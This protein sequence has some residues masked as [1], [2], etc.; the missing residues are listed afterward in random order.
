M[1]S[2]IILLA[3]LFAIASSQRVE[4]QA[5]KYVLMEHFTNAGCAPCAAQNPIFDTAILKRNY[6]RVHHLTYHTSWPGTDPM[7]TYNPA[8][9]QSRVTYYDVTGVPDIELS[10]NQ[11]SGIPLGVSQKMVDKASSQNSPV[12]IRVKQTSNGASRDVQI[13][14]YSLM[15]VPSASYVIRAAVLEKEINY[16]TPPGS[17]GEKHFPD[18]FRKMLP[19]VT[20]DTYSPAPQGDSVVFNYNFTLD[21]SNWDTSK[22][23][24]IAFIQNNTSKAILNSGSTIDPDWEAVS[25]S[26][27]FLGSSKNST[28]IFNYKLY[29]LSDSASD[30]MIRLNSE[31]PAGWHSYFEINSVQRIDSL[32]INL[33][34]KTVTDF[35]LTVET[36]NSPAVSDH[37]LSVKCLNDT[38]QSQVLISHIMQ[39]ITDLIIN[40]DAPWGDGN[41]SRTEEF[42]KY[43]IRGLEAAG[44]NT[45]STIT[46]G[47]YLKG[48]E[49]TVLNDCKY[50]YFNVG[51]SF[52]GFTDENV[53]IFKIILDNGGKLMVSGQDV[54]WDTWDLT[55]GGNGTTNTQSF[56]T[57]YL[58]ASW[59][60][61][62]GTSNNNLIVNN[63]DAIF[64]LTGTSGIVNLYGNGNNG[65]YFYPDQINAT[66]NGI[67]IFYYNNT[68]KTAAVR[69]TNGTYR[70]VYLGFSLEQLQDSSVK[71]QIMELTH[72]WF[73]NIITGI[74]FDNSVNNLMLG[75]SI[76]NPAD[77]Y[78]Y[79]PVEN[80]PNESVLY[81]F[82]IKGGKIDEYIIPAGQSQ[83]RLNTVDLD[84]GTYFYFIHNGKNRSS[85]RKI[86]VIH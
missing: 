80:I 30:F 61:D 32:Q 79:I 81:I 63:S 68:S 62:G 43:F 24:I 26:K 16:A 3:I 50:L 74:E 56:Y 39:G 22:I 73:H 18:V 13:I 27:N 37:I 17:N 46:L 10:G 21:L 20:G 59:V 33:P 52:P 47:T 51:W 65:P 19:N 48:I 53:A 31:Q 2:I 4:A 23:Y 42:Q 55:N 9:V 7:N 77:E 38:F 64:G 70:T 28:K 11:Y 1:K 29:N 34:P 85:T 12:R 83:F 44:N 57:N 6:G 25:V 40:N 82:N 75:Q 76:P 35:T 69:S 71:I 66:G 8:E 60:D 58:N 36:D 78:T 41:S 54:G 49:D 84:N 72:D 5:K 86:T 67:P 45:F 14:V 15:P